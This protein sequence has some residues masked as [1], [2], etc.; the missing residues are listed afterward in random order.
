VAKYC[1]SLAKQ[2]CNYLSE[3]W[4]TQRPI[5]DSMQAALCNVAIPVP[6]DGYKWT[7]DQANNRLRRDH[8]AWAVLYER[9][10]KRYF[11]LSCQIYN[12]FDEYVT[13]ASIWERV[14][15]QLQEGQ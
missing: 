9:D 14:F 8:S 3:R 11:R 13:F 1:N 10:G 12:H 5:P 7:I 4:G 6:A 15:L 2:V